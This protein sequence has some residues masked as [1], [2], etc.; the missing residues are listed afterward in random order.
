[1]ICTHS[2]Q[3]MRTDIVNYNVCV[4]AMDERWQGQFDDLLDIA[5]VHYL[6]R[7]EIIPS[8]AEITPASFALAG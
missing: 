4:F 6:P 5:Q 7:A 1:V 3:Q 2:L 8:G